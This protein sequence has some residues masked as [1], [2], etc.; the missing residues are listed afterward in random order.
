ME[1]FLASLVAIILGLILSPSVMALAIWG[2]VKIGGADVLG[3]VCAVA[4]GVA[5]FVLLVWKAP[6]II[7]KGLDR[8]RAEAPEP[9]YSCLAMGFA[10]A[11]TIGAFMAV[12]ILLLGHT[13]PEGWELDRIPGFGVKK[14]PTDG[15]I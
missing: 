1:R 10:C 9:Y 2:W 14:S 7:R 3:M 12:P 5:V 6:V 8:L 13:R 15:T 4:A 11:F